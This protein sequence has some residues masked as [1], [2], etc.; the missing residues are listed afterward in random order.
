M[1]TISS[2]A[3]PFASP[4]SPGPLCD[5]PGGCEFQS[6][7]ASTGVCGVWQF[8]YTLTPCL[9]GEVTHDRPNPATPPRKTVTPCEFDANSSSKGA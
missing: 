4:L 6:P 7:P 9:T 2:H 1:A 3:R 5:R 8:A